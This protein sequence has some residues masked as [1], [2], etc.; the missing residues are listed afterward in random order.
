MNRIIL[1]VAALIL[2]LSLCACNGG[3]NPGTNPSS[4]NPAQTATAES[5]QAVTSEPTK[6]ADNRGDDFEDDLPPWNGFDFGRNLEYREEH[7]LQGDP[8]EYLST[9]E[10]AKV[11]FDTAKENGNIPDYSDS[12]EYSMVLV[13]LEDIEGEECYLY[14]LDVDE[15]SGTVGA[16]Y[17]YAYQSGNIYMQGHGG[18]FVLILNYPDYLPSYHGANTN[19]AD[20]GWITVRDMLSIPPD[21]TYN[22]AGTDVEVSGFGGA[23]DLILIVGRWNPGYYERLEE[24]NLSREEFLFDDGNWGDL[25]EMNGAYVWVN[26]DMYL[27]FGSPDLPGGYYYIYFDN[28]EIITSIAKTLTDPNK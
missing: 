8:G 4:S 10:A 9:F 28:I 18:R 3:G 27:T 23:D 20:T 13:D 2:A 11:T 17:A 6:A 16:A 14:R 5:S 1:I 15:P 24:N 12:T 25:F 7:T 21:W 26:G 22:D 19:T